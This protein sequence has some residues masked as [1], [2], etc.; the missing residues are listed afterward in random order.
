MEGYLFLI[1]LLPFIGF[2]IN[3]LLGQKIGKSG[4]FCIGC[5]SIGL[6]FLFSIL[7]VYQL[8][9]SP[10]EDRLLVQVL[11]SWMAVGNLNIDVSLMID[12]L[13]AVMVLVVTGVSFVIHI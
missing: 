4:V 3:G 7:A 6:A 9:C 12:P 13:S 1:P 10:P 5:S 11:W 2:L 8:A